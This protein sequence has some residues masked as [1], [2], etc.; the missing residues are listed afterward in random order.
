[1]AYRPA[2]WN[3]ALLFLISRFPVPSGNRLNSGA[4]HESGQRRLSFWALIYQAALIFRLQGRV[5]R[6][7]AGLM[8]H[9]A[10]TLAFMHE[11][12]RGDQLIAVNFLETMHIGHLTP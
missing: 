3:D 4:D 2:T 7:G 1:M 9:Q 6:R 8:M 5:F 11:D 12:I 10:P